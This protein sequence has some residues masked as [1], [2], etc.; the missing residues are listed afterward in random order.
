MV[1]TPAKCYSDQIRENERGGTCSTYFG[2]DKF[3]AVFGGKKLKDRT[4]WKILVQ[5]GI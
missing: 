4:T 5:M 3:I 2:E 1:F